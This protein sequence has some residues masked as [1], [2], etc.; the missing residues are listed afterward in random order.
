LPGIL[1]IILGLVGKFQ[2]DKITGWLM[3]GQETIGSVV[4]TVTGES[5]RTRAQAL[6]GIEKNASTKTT[7]NGHD[8]SDSEIGEQ[9]GLKIIKAEQNAQA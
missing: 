8:Y 4:A 6:G 1:T 3:K 7:L 9:F 2:G 5:L